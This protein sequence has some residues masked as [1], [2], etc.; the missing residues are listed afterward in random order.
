M[1]S[2]TRRIPG[3]SGGTSIASLTEECG[4]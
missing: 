2:R 1:T 4:G 3:F